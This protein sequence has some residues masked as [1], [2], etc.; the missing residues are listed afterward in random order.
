MSNEDS[1]ESFGTT[2]AVSSNPTSTNSTAA[3]G[4]SRRKREAHDRRRYHSEKN[5][6]KGKDTSHERGMEH[7]SEDMSNED[8]SEGFG[9]TET[10]SS[11]STVASGN[12]RRKRGF[13]SRQHLSGE[14]LNEI[15]NRFDEEEMAE[16][17]EY[18]SKEDSFEEDR[19]LGRRDPYKIT[20]WSLGSYGIFQLR[21]SHFCD[22]GYRWSRNLC[23]KSCTDFTDDDITDDIDCFL[24]EFFDGYLL[25]TRSLQCDREAETYLQDCS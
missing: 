20:L 15:E 3:T 18:M 1:A 17:D 5:G 23:Q 7:D 8:S 25:R 22:S 12:S 6:G 19:F 2:E 10:V 11:N 4:S 9:T 14:T 16:D 13:L 21:D 24:K